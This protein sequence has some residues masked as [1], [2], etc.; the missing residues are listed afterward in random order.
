M[1]DFVHYI[2]FASGALYLFCY[3]F[4]HISRDGKTYV[5]EKKD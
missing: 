4:V 3:G 1:R 5:V 2:L